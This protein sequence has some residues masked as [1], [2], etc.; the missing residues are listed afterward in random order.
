MFFDLGCACKALLTISIT[1]A[2]DTLPER[3]EVTSHP[4]YD[5]EMS[6][7]SELPDMTGVDLDAYKLPFDGEL[8]ERFLDF[9]P[10]E[11][12]GM[13]TVDSLL[14]WISSTE[15]KGYLQQWK[16]RVLSWEKGCAMIETSFSLSERS[17]WDTID[18][19]VHL[20]FSCDSSS[21]FDSG[22]A[23][24][25]TACVARCIALASDR[26]GTPLQGVVAKQPY[27]SFEVAVRL[28]MTAYCDMRDHNTGHFMKLLEGPALPRFTARKLRLSHGM[29]R[30]NN[31]AAFKDSEKDH[32]PTTSSRSI[33]DG[34]T[35][36]VQR[37]AEHISR[38]YTRR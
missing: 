21:V 26:K 6:E 17:A 20:C 12:P 15:V 14:K 11:A 19:L 35:T 3:N 5:A 28:L 22:D 30:F 24:E 37:M 1:S 33:G 9:P 8:L 36:L 29:V 34:I 27:W 38:E 18:T 23:F 13:M 10:V 2:A 32:G 25:M 4:P 31:K 16:N 7:E